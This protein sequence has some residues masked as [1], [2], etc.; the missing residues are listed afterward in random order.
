MRM[1]DDA[2]DLPG[3][4]EV[5]LPAGWRRPKGYAQA[6]RAP[7]GRDL[8]F[9]AGQVG[10]DEDER[11]VSEDFPAQFERALA[12]CVSIVEAAGGAARDIVRL[13]MYCTDRNTYLGNRRLVGEAY[14]RVM[15]HHYPAMSLL[16]VAALVEPGAQ[17]EIEATAAV[18]PAIAGDV[19]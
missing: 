9:V 4:P 19:S 16:E 8:V 18:P 12:N 2:L 13:T 11:L 15:G 7:A 10:W 14:R 6:M 5:V 17:I 3:P 1:A